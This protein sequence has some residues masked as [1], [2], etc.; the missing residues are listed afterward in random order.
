MSWDNAVGIMDDGV[1]NTSGSVYLRFQSMGLLGNLTN[2]PVP[3]A[4]GGGVIPGG[5]D[6]GMTAL[7]FWTRTRLRKMEVTPWRDST[8]GRQDEFADEFED[9][10]DDEA[11][12]K[13]RGR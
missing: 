5:S 1:W 8:M 12:N 11:P 13:K 10:G 3:P 7:S 9:P 6:V 4:G 2:I